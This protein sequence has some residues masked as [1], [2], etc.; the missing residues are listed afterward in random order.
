MNK[1]I[2]RRTSVA[3]LIILRWMCGVIRENRIINKDIIRGSV[4]VASVVG[5]K[6]RE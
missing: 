5:K 2:E 6:E 3:E 1:I 4:G